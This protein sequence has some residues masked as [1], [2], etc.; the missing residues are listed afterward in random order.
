MSLLFALLCLQ[1]G[2]AVEE[3]LRKLDAESIEVRT[4]AADL[5]MQRGAAV[6]PALEAARA[7]AGPELQRRLDAL[8]ARARTRER[9]AGRMPPP[10]RVTLAM[11]DVPLREAVARIRAGTAVG[12]ADKVADRPVTV[13]LENVPFWQ[14]LDRIAQAAGGT[15]VVPGPA[16]AWFAPGAQEKVPRAHVDGFVVQLADVA[17]SEE[18]ELGAAT[19]S[20]R[21][22]L[23]L[24]VGWERGTRPTR[25]RAVLERFEEEGGRNL[26][27]DEAQPPEAVLTDPEA[28]PTGAELQLR[29]SGVPSRDAARAAIRIRVEADFA[30]RWGELVFPAPWA[31]DQARETAD[32][33]ARIL[34][35]DPRLGQQTVVLQVFPRAP[36]AAP[37][38]ALLLSVRDDTGRSAPLH[39]TTRTRDAA[40]VVVTG[41]VT[42][43]P[44]RPL[45]DL[46]IR[47]PVEVHTERFGIDLP[48]VSLR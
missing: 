45:K 15:Q 32:V 44:G 31:S 30:L 23:T 34:A 1:D 35:S 7:E 36:G 42:P 5:L 4:E 13:T 41:V 46:R 37:D 20:S 14:A 17:A 40:G 33:A 29:F 6:I 10:T 24:R 8:L 18:M 48:E 47:V 19:R 26:V 2:P 11:K 38:V 3:L 12:A 16:G 28:H 21:T 39:V 27:A 9:L 43:V 25:V 22:V